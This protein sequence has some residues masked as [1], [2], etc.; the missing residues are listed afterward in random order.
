MLLVAYIGPL[1]FSS[2]QQFY[3]FLPNQFFGKGLELSKWR[4]LKKKQQWL[5]H[6]SIIVARVVFPL[7]K[8]AYVKYFCQCDTELLVKKGG[9]S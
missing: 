6:P 2:C 4:N 8:N 1:N 9:M 3:L 7:N 5:V